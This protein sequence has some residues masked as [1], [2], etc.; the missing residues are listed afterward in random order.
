MSSI[1]KPRVLKGFRDFLPEN[2]IERKAI[3]NKLEKNFE[4]FGFVP[5]DF[6]KASCEFLPLFHIAKNIF[7][8]ISLS[9]AFLNT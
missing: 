5:I 7:A 8:A 6:K 9:T 1:I 4:S 3:C 2:E